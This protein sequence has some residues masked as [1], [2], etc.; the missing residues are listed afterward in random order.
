MEHLN[1]DDVALYWYPRQGGRRPLASTRGRLVDH[2]GLSVSNLDAWTVKLRSQGVPFL[3]GPYT[4]GGVRAVMIEGP[5]HE[6]IEL[7]EDK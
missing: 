7:L 6:A 1:Y 4:L 3:E 5:S 2:I